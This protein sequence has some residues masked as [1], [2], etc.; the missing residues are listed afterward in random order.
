[1][2]FVI[3][4]AGAIGGQLAKAGCEVLC[5]EKLPEHVAAIEAHGL[6]LR[7]QIPRSG[8]GGEQR[9]RL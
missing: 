5:I 3:C 7:A 6:Q 8:Q 2:R 9:L 4:G 1:M